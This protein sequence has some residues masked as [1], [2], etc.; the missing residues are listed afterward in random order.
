[1]QG[2]E[3]DRRMKGAFDFEQKRGNETGKGRWGK[4]TGK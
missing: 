4:K 1:M 3:W 2:R